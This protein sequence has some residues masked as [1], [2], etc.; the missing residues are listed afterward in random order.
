[1]QA[2]FHDEQAVDVLARINQLARERQ[3]LLSRRARRL[4]SDDE[5]QCLHAIDA[6]IHAGWE[7]RRRALARVSPAS[8]PQ[9]REEPESGDVE[10]ASAPTSGEYRSR[11]VGW[12]S[13][14]SHAVCAYEALEALTCR[15]CDHV[16]R[17]GEVFTR[18][19]A[20]RHH[21]VGPLCQR[22]RPIAPL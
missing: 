18:G 9:Y 16:I 17:S 21:A 22:C 15:E 12:V 19:M 3:Q 5:V 6:A 1:M 10:L 2:E 20:R 13:H 8:Q 7:E 11:R 4:L 14:Y